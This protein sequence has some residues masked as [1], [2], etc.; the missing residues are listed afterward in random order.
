[1][2][3]SRGSFRARRAFSLLECVAALA[4]FAAASVMIAQ[5]CF[6]CVSSLDTL[7][8]DSFS[9]ALKDYVRAAV[10]AEQSLDTL[11]SGFDVE[12]PGGES[13]RV[14][15]AA[16]KTGIADLFQLDYEVSSGGRVYSESLFVIRKN[17][18]ENSLDRDEIMKD[19]RDFLEDKRR[20]AQF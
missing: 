19:R 2:K 15:A 18:Y 3:E 13:A 1:M 14:S 17:W 11:E 6:N 20:N 8:K 4:L 12:L 9:N 7:K 10:L 5:A 16:Q